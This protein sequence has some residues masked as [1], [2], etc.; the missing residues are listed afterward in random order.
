MA[1]LPRNKPDI[2]STAVWTGSLIMIAAFAAALVSC[3]G[4]GSLMSNGGTGTVHVSITDPPSCKVPN[5]GFQ[6]VFVTI[7][8]VQAHTSATA[9]D[10][11]PGWQEFAPQLN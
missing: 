1:L 4:S 2:L 11:S 5:G 9:D 10:D 8:S 7:R 3:G 6:H